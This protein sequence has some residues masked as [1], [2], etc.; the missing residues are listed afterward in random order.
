[1]AFL[2]LGKKFRTSIGML[3]DKCFKVLNHSERR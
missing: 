1:V 2:F 3:V